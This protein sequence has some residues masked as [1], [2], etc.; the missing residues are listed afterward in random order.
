M[1]IRAVLLPLFF[2]VALVFVLLFWRRP[3]ASNEPVAGDYRSELGLPVLF[4]VLT[5]LAW[6][7]KFSDFLFVVMAWLFVVLRILHALA[8][9][10]S[11]ARGA[12]SA[13]FISSAIVLAL[14][15]LIYALRILLGLG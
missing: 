15:W 8:D 14:M 2:H 4:Y 9:A 1:S 11:R 3:T 7:T 6:V 12:T 10:T 13:L 5:I